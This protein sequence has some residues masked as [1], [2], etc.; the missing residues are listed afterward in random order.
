MDVLAPC[1]NNSHLESSWHIPALKALLTE[2]DSLNTC[3]GVYV[4]GAI[5]RLDLVNPVILSLGRLSKIFFRYLPNSDRGQDILRVITK[6]TI[7]SNLDLRAV[8]ED[9][10]CTDF[11]SVFL[12]LCFYCILIMC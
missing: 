7:F 5:N 4:I 1:D 6:K 11:R 10:Q 3:K 2:L 12:N 8:A 9:P